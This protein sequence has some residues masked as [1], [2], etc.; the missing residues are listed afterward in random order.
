MGTNNSNAP[1]KSLVVGRSG[2]VVIADGN[3]Y[4]L[5]PVPECMGAT[6]ADL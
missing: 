6:I 4:R 2:D 5:P 1:L 3:E